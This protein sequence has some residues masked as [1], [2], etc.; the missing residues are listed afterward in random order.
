MF[1]FLKTDQRRDC[2]ADDHVL[3]NRAH[4]CYPL[5]CDTMHD[6]VNCQIIHSPHVRKFI[7]IVVLLQRSLDYSGTQAHSAVVMIKTVHWPLHETS[8]TKEFRGTLFI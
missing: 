4:W 5:F 1:F 8:S 2:S 3:V 6:P 7:Q